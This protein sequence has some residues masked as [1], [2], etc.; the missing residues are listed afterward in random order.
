MIN[1]T[2]NFDDIPGINGYIPAGYG[3][4]NW[5]DLLL[6]LNHSEAPPEWGWGQYSKNVTSGSTF[7]FFSPIGDQ[8]AGFESPDGQSFDLTSANM[9]YMWLDH[10]V[11]VN[12]NGYEDGTLKYSQHVVLGDYNSGWGS[13]PTPV[14][15]GWQGVDKVVFNSYGNNITFDDIVLGSGSG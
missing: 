10:T 3:G 11:G 1:Q 6:F 5:T 4:L 15:F 2:L 8:T 9:N 13:V 14:S 7:M 12:V